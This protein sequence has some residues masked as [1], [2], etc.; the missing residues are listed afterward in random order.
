MTAPVPVPPEEEPIASHDELAEVLIELVN[1]GVLV[2]RR[3]PETGELRFYPP[4][5]LDGVTARKGRE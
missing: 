5:A 1:A 2:L 3:D 4:D